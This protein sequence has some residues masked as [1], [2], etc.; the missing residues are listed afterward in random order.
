LWI[1]INIAAQVLVAALSL[2]WSVDPS[3]AVPLLAYGN[4]TVANLQEWSPG[5]VD[6][7]T[8]WANVTYMQDATFAGMEGSVYPVFPLSTETQTNLGILPGTPLY[9]DEGTGVYEYRF[10][11]RNP[12][13]P[14]ENYAAS[15]RKIRATASCVELKLN[16]TSLEDYRYIDDG[17]NGTNHRYLWAKVGHYWALVL[18]KW[19][20]TDR[21]TGTW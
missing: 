2:F 9:H 16:G 1:L 10:Y 14:F 21:K 7:D 12:A 11:N 4:V 19:T 15:G 5:V 8:S 20:L 17:E 18:Q 13:S 3:N 6:T